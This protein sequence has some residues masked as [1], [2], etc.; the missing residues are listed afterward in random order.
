MVTQTIWMYVGDLYDVCY[1]FFEAKICIF[2][3]L[4]SEKSGKKRTLLPNYYESG[5]SFA[6]QE[7]SRQQDAKELQFV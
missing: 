7:Q 1:I 2:D 5:C 3:T 4:F 6:F